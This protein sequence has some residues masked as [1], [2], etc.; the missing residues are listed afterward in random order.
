MST[1]P[2]PAISP[3]KQESAT[4]TTQQDGRSFPSRVARGFWTQRHSGR[5]ATP[6]RFRSAKALILVVDLKAFSVHLLLEGFK[7]KKSTTT[8]NVLYKQE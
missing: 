5:T 1:A 2:S 4:K 6:G 7:R 8:K 3:K